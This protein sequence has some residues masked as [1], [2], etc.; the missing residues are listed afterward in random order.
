MVIFTLGF[1]LET[2]SEVEINV[3]EVVNPTSEA[4]IAFQV[5]ILV[6]SA[7]EWVCL[8]WSLLDEGLQAVEVVSRNSD[9]RSACVQDCYS[10]L[11]LVGA[12]ID[13]KCRHRNGPMTTFSLVTT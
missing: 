10:A 12:A 6:N 7:A 8:A 5:S 3:W 13:L 4:A 9:V 2:A 11:Q 1:T